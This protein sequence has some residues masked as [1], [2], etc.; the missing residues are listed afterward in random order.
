MLG[1]LSARL[2]AVAVLVGVS[3]VVLPRAHVAAGSATA[4][5]GRTTSRKRVH[6]PALI[7]LRFSRGKVTTLRGTAVPRRAEIN[8]RRKARRRLR[9]VRC[10]VK[11]T[12]RRRSIRTRTIVRWLAKIRCT[13]SML[14]RGRAYLQRTSKH[15]VA[16][17]RRYRRVGRR[18]WSGRARTV[19]RSPHQSLYVRDVVNVYFPTPRRSGQISIYPSRPRVLGPSSRCLSASFRKRRLGVH[20]VL[21]TARK[22]GAR[23][24]KHPPPPPP[25]RHVV[26]HIAW[27]VMENH[28]YEQI[29]GDTR[30][31]PYINSLAARFGSATQMFAESHP[32]LP[33]YIAMTSG[34]TQGIS[35]D[36]G[37]SSHRLNV[38]NIF[39]QLPGGRARSLVQSMPSSCDRSDS[40]PYAVRHN[41]QVYYTNLGSCAAFDVPFGSRPDLSA[42]F[43]LITP[44][45]C[46]DMHSNSCSGSNDVIAQGDRFLQSY[47]PQLIDSPQYRAGNTVIFITW[48]ED[49]GSNSNHIPTLVLDPF[50]AH[51]T[52]ACAD[53][54]YTHYSMLQ[55]VED[56]FGLSRI[57]GATAAHSMRGCFGLP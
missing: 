39:N 18:A 22:P 24:T 3:L 40:T 48:D 30:D 43:T 33:N 26:H 42:E 54:H 4:R 57:G 12:V 47:V 36:S 49:S 2:A 15:I 16:R 29:I 56:T 55:Y 44:D 13:R 14:L 34:S 19:I 21:Y 9:T 6:R 10:A 32:S 7:T 1:R 28:S 8:L 51:T 31:A 46:H 17:G 20:C 53:A 23:R 41:P 38:P 25:T 35:D 45:V 11:L 37:P 50:G 27:V 52:A 5:V